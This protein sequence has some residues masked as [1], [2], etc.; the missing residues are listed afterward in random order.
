MKT[1]NSAGRSTDW[2]TLVL[3]VVRRL[4]RTFSLND[5]TAHEDFFRR[6]YPR[7]NFIAAKIRQSLQ[8]LRDQGTLLFLGNAHYQRIDGDPK[9]SPL[10][11]F[12]IGKDYVSASQLARVAVETWAELN[13]Y[14]VNCSVRELTRLPDNTRVRDFVCT[15]CQ[16]G[17]Q[18]KSLQGRFGG[19]L[20]GA[21]YG[22][23]IEAV[24][25]G[26]MPEHI[27][28]EYDRRFSTVVWVHA[29]PGQLITEERVIPRKRLSET[30]RRKGWQGC[31]IDL[32]DVP[33]VA[34]AAPTHQDE[35]I[36]RENWR[37]VQSK[38][39]RSVR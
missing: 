27:L 5:V 23:T 2:K 21:A 28:V 3:D 9:F 6:H 37:A 36:V 30:A 13:L 8:I 33:K 22:P 11:N 32:S 31:T 38:A 7:N 29:Y 39:R 1:D 14:C 19:K 20:T 16:T 12:D 24:R 35:E 10:V 4:P 34:L 17:Y 18:L 15:S 25:E 26:L